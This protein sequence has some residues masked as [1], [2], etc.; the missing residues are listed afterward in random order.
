[1]VILDQSKIKINN[2][3]RV[4][5][6]LSQERSLTKNKVA[7]ILDISIPTVT[8]IVNEL[9]VEGICKQGGTATS[10]GGR[11]PVIIEFLPDSRYSIGVELRKKYVKVILTNLDSKIISYIKSDLKVIDGDVILD[12]I[13]ENIEKI[14]RESKVDKKKVLGIGISLPGTINEKELRLEV[15]ANFHLKN[16]GFIE[17]QEFFNLPVYLENEA[18]AGALG[19]LVLGT[20]KALKNFIYISITEGV[21]GGLIIDGKIYKGKDH[22]A[23]EIGH[24]T[25]N[26][27]GR[28]CNC[29]KKGCWETYASTRA[30]LNTYNNALCEIID[31]KQA[32]HKISMEEIVDRYNDEDKMAI[33][34]IGEYIEDLALGIQ[35]L[36]YIFNPDNIVIGGDISEYKESLLRKIKKKVYENNEFY[37]EEDVRIQFSKLK[38]D[39]N[40]I[41]ASILP[42]NEGFGFGKIS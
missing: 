12:N 21:G 2:K 1:M 26:K 13:R 31:S 33:K 41:G 9:I 20:A 23:G 28:Q 32:E 27:H 40:V 7:K 10:T 37:S 8:T 38:G 19:E 35:N 15:A 29:G 16:L 39:S 14:V 3:K 4:I 22:R 5:K 11:K 6:L 36:M 17:L 25:I 18:N 34:I 24:M 42:I 30:L